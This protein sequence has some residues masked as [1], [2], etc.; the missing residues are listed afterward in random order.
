MKSAILFSVFAALAAADTYPYAS[1][2]IKN[3]DPYT[4]RIE[5][6]PGNGA[7]GSGCTS[8]DTGLGGTFQSGA[9]LHADKGYKVNFYFNIDCSDPSP[10]GLDIPITTERIPFSPEDNQRFHS[11]K[12]AIVFSQDAYTNPDYHKPILP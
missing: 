8:L 4:W 12:A 3:G 9:V 11:A 6:I 7:E 10:P 2:E 5:S 1:I